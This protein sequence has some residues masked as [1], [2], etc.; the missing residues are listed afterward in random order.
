MNPAPT[1]VDGLDPGAFRFE[2][3]CEAIAPD[4]TRIRIGSFPIPSHCLLCAGQVIVDDWATGTA[5]MNG[6]AM[7]NV[8]NQPGLLC[9]D[10][11]Q[12]ERQ[13]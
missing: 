12:K 9:V 4:D 8:N 7:A 1:P 3:V 2:Y 10:C 6:T 13:S 5:H 11:T